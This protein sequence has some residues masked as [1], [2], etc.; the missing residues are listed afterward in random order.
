MPRF[1]PISRE[2]LGTCH[3]DLQRV[4]EEVIKTFDCKVIEG[5]RNKKDQNA[6][7]NAGRSKILWPNGNHNKTPSTA[8]D[9]VPYPIDWND[10]ERFYFFGGYVLGVAQSVGISLR[11]GGDWDSDTQL[12]DQSFFDLPHFELL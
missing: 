6:A 11:W 7:F 10:K 5:F 4:F 1:G 9:V 8:A 2:S 3:P 12:H